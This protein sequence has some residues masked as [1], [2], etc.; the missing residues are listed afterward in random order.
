MS[1]FENTPIFV[2]SS[3]IPPIPDLEIP[4]IPGFTPSSGLETP[5]ILEIPI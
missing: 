2:L 1:R 5:Q 4:P 3:K